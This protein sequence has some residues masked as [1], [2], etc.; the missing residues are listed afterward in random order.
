MYASCTSE[1]NIV[2][3]PSEVIVGCR[4]RCYISSHL[5][6]AGQGVTNDRIGRDNEDRVR[7]D[8]NS[9]IIQDIGLAVRSGLTNAY[10]I[11]VSCQVAI[12]GLRSLTVV[13]GN[14]TLD[15]F[16]VA[17]P[18]INFAARN[19]TADVS[20]HLDFATFAN[21]V[22]YEVRNDTVNNRV[23][24]NHDGNRSDIETALVVIVHQMCNLNFVCGV[25]RRSK[26][27]NRLS[28]AGDS[29]ADFVTVSIPLILKHRIVVIV[30]M[31]RQGHFTTLADSSLVGSDVNLGFAVDVNL[32]RFTHSRTTIG[33]GDFNR[34]R[35]RIVVR[36]NPVLGIDIIINIARNTASTYL[37]MF[38]P[39]V[40][41]VRIVSSVNP[42]NQTYIAFAGVRV[43]S[44]IAYVVVTRNRDDRITFNVY[45]VGVHFVRFATFDTEVDVSSV[46]V[47]SSVV[48]KDV[49]LF[50]ESII[51]HTLHQDAVLIPNVVEIAGISTFNVSGYINVFAFAD[52]EFIT[53][54]VVLVRYDKFEF[55]LFGEITSR[56]NF[57]RSM[58]FSNTFGR[59]L[60]N[61]DEECCIFSNSSRESA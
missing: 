47:R 34:E 49:E 39:S 33:V 55:E 6:V 7:E 24:I 30:K 28:H 27:L 46:C 26:S 57:H 19:A 25:G 21:G 36:R 10:A 59:C 14:C 23:V 20:S 51:V 61:F 29:I 2:L 54:S 32:E 8:S 1:S 4:S 12:V 48:I 58:S 5:N 53:C 41:K 44:H 17:V 38:V 13:S 22:V 40:G 52:R 45:R 15:D 35:V 42:S 50:V 43:R 9:S 60:G 11:N 16:A 31:S 37:I 18:S 56:N 3:I